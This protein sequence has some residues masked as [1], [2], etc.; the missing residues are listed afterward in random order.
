MIKKITLLSIALAAIT[1]SSCREVNIPRIEQIAPNETAFLVPLT[2]DKGSQV[3]FDSESFL[4]ENKISV[5]RVEIPQVWRSTG[6]AYWTGEYIPSVILIKVDRAP[7][8]AQWEPSTDKEG[9]V[10]RKPGDNSVWIESQ[11]SVGFSVGF[12]VSAYIEAKNA[13]KF[14][15]MYAGRPLKDVLNTEVHGRVLEVAQTFASELPLDKLRE[16]KGEMSLQIQ[17]DVIAFFSQRGITVTNIGMFGGFSYENQEIQGAIDK[18]FISQQL[19]NTTKAALE[20]QQSTNERLIS[21]A[22]AEAD[23]SMQKA[24]GLS[25]SAVFKAKGEAE[26]I[27]LRAK[28]LVAASSNPLYI[29]FQEL[30]IAKE[31]NTR[32]NGQLPVNYVGSDKVTTV[33]GVPGNV[34]PIPPPV[35]E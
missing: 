14:L 30:E 10:I 21:E 24:E 9:N 26:A 28:A 11:D 34:V 8:T 20:A 35:K 32:W 13:S 12:N 1:L 7:V 29:K 15:Y 4:E 16:K 25:K 18:V 6:R 3:K 17:K 33:L 23:A 19:K 27:E 2:G 31:F 22:K 5:G